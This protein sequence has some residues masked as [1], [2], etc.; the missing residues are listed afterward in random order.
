VTTEGDLKGIII[1]GPA[2]KDEAAAWM[3]GDPLCD[4]G[5][6]V[7]ELFDWFTIPGQGIPA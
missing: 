7:Y 4:R 5:I 1:F 2:D 6:F 3:Q